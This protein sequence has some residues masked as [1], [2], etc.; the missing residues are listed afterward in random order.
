MRV[1]VRDGSLSSGSANVD[2]PRPDSLP[3]AWHQLLKHRWRRE[4]GGGEGGSLAGH[5][6]SSDVRGGTHPGTHPPGAGQERISNLAVGGP[7]YAY[8]PMLC[9]SVQQC[10][11]HP[12]PPGDQ[13]GGY[14]ARPCPYQYACGT[15]PRCR[16]LRMPHAWQ[17]ALLPLPPI[18]QAQEGGGCSDSVSAA[19]FYRVTGAACRASPPRMLKLHPPEKDIRGLSEHAWSC[20]VCA[21]LCCV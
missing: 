7:G 1:L 6:R 18:L 17:V 3:W 12:S 9:V 11:A 16:M 10:R 19:R 5:L 2:A 13:A 21:V 14:T 20:A 4:W 8:R 15:G